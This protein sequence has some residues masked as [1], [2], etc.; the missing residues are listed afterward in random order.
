MDYFHILNL[1]REPFSNA[2]DPAYFYHSRQHVGCLQKLELSLRLRR[3]LNVVTGEVGTGK[4]TLCRQL[5]QRFAAD[6]D[7]ETHLILDPDFP[8][9]SAFLSTVAAMICDGQPLSGDDWRIKEHIK[10]ALFEKGVEQGRTVVL[11]IDEGQKIRTACLEILRELLNYETNEAKL[12][13]IV[14]FAQTEFDRTLDDHANV[15]DRISLYHRLGPLGFSDTRKMIRFR[16]IQAGAQ[17]NA[18]LFFTLPA[19]WAIYL[20]TRGF[21]RKIVH[22]CHK[23]VL[24]MIIQNRKKAGWFLVRS[25]ARRSYQKT[26]RSRP[27]RLVWL[28]GALVLGIVALGGYGIDPTLLLGRFVTSQRMETVSATSAPPLSQYSTSVTVLPP[29]PPTPKTPSTKAETG[30]PQTSDEEIPKESPASGP[31]VSSDPGL[32]AAISPETNTDPMIPPNAG[33]MAVA[34][35]PADSASTVLPAAATP[36][37]DGVAGEMPPH[38][39][40]TTALKET[41]IL[42][43]LMIKLYGDFNNDLLGQ[44]AR[45]NPQI[46]D[47]DNI[48]AGMPLRLPAI[49]ATNIRRRGTGSWIQLTETRDLSEAVDFIRRYP[50]KAPA[51]RVVPHW[52]R[53]N[54]LRFAVVLW[55]RF[56]ND[57]NVR[58]Q[59]EALPEA[60]TAG[61]RL[62]YR[63]DS[64]ATYFSDPYRIR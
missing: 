62:V 17:G 47:P 20:A 34:M 23:A 48:A 11:I 30:L 24:A 33:A 21:P 18:R 49:E 59:I 1:D 7:T 27:R 45:A 22:L 13:Q 31:A 14:I 6:D 63:W 26:G 50:A 46:H 12:L 25:C 28:T 29:T 16:L 57:D 64:A 10:T 56:D 58:R 61:S 55:A 53:A 8:D 43:W 38:D 44:V 3:G 32:F 41:E 60:L 51:A 54:G 19:I 4:T 15:A 2:P 36:V 5:I 9:A 37:A 39:L 52:S 40:G 35:L 42:S